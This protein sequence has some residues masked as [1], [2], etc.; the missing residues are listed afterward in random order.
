MKRVV[1]ESLIKE[2][3]CPHGWNAQINES[4]GYDQID[5]VYHTTLYSKFIVPGVILKV[6]AENQSLFVDELA[7]RSRHA[8]QDLLVVTV[9]KA[10]EIGIKLGHEADQ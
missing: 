9:S 4:G 1:L 3:F 2:S 8:L 10:N 6:A 5:V 7:R